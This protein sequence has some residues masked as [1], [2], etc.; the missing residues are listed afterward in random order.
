MPLPT[1]PT[2]YLDRAGLDALLGTLTV[3]KAAAAMA[4]DVDAMLISVC[5]MADGYVIRQLGTLPPAPA[6][7]AQVA[8]LVAEIVL[9][10]LY[11]GTPNE[12]IAKRGEAAMRALRDIAAG[13]FQLYRVAVADDPDTPDVD[14]SLIGD[15][16]CG[17][18][19]R[20][21]SD[22]GTAAD[23]EACW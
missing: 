8:P 11:A 4:S 7:L 13:H 2:P 12:L 18:G 22:W 21:L 20:V 10:K 23:R 3:A 5:A 6:A 1:S 19:K 16:A 9:S 14:E 15:A 17:S